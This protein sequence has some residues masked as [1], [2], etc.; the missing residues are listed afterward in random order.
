MSPIK[1]ISKFNRKASSTFSLRLHY[2]LCSLKKDDRHLHDINV[3]R[4][5]WIN[6][7]PQD[8]NMFSFKVSSTYGFNIF[9][10]IYTRIPPPFL[11]SLS[12]LC[13][14]YPLII[15]IWDLTRTKGEVVKIRMSSFCSGL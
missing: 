11:P 4:L 3:L 10:N 7:K 12:F 15:L 2:T 8:F 6:F 14:L 13:K 5:M 1:I 9:I